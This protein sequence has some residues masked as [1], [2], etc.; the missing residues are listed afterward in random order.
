[1]EAPNGPESLPRQLIV[2]CD[3]TNNTLTAGSH[4]TNV[5]RLMNM[6]RPGE[7]NQKLYYDPGVGTADQLPSTGMGDRVS[8]KLE[9]LRGLASGGGIY[10]NI[11]SAYRF[12]AENYRDGDQIF[13]FGF[14]RGAFTARAVAGMVN[15]CGLL[16]LHNMELLDTL[17]AAY[18]SPANDDEVPAGKRAQRNVIDDIGSH[19]AAHRTVALHF[20]GVFDTVE[21]VGLPGFRRK[22][23]S[24]GMASTKAYVH[25]R[26]ALSLDEMR[27]SFTPRVYWE[28]DYDQ[29]DSNGTRRSLKQRWFRGVHAD[30]GGGYPEDTVSATGQA[31]PP[32]PQAP[33][34]TLLS[35]QAL[36]WMIDE[37]Q[38]CGLRIDPDYAPQRAGLPVL[39]NEAIASPWWAVAGMV[40]RRRSLPRKALARITK[41]G[42]KGHAPYDQAVLT[43]AGQP[44]ERWRPPGSPWFQHGVMLCLLLLFLG[45]ANAYAHAAFHKGSFHLFDD[46]GVLF[47]GGWEFDHW[48]RAAFPRFEHALAGV[49]AGYA[50]W[51]V[52]FDLG[53]IATYAWFLGWAAIRVFL[54][55]TGMPASPDAPDAPAWLVAAVGW[56]PCFLVA[57]DL[58][59]DLATLAALGTD[60]ALSPV[61]PYAA[62][63]VMW[64]ANYVKWLALGLTLVAF[65]LGLAFPVAAHHAAPPPQA[66]GGRH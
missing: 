21:S 11:G 34:E 46:P 57:S 48:Q 31:A 65:A 41:L 4:D 14:S 52:V 50:A 16:Q 12:L 42:D 1:M 7:K 6:L 32:N 58:V 36:H 44:V 62:A 59:E 55:V 3:G 23:T 43:N 40:P 19:F 24:D 28:N 8:R 60:A 37:A 47:T 51:A 27:W 53:F 63:F 15:R 10:E 25:V 33:R 20:I 38:G 64:V 61:L 45:A 9:R 35:N 22:F 39:H 66:R 18:F 30:I 56:L 17:I 5:V 49:D 2:C 54:R 13:L 26:Q 29:T